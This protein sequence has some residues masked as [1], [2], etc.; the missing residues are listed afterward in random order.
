[1]LRMLQM[2]DHRA[3]RSSWLQTVD[4]HPILWVLT[5]VTSSG[6]QQQLEGRDNP[7]MGL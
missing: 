5:Q 6:H 7:S 4:Y 2:A 1:M 3:S